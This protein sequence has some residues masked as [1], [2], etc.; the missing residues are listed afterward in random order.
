LLY[1]VVLYIQDGPK[2]KPLSMIVAY[3]HIIEKSY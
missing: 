2:S 3:Y 1:A